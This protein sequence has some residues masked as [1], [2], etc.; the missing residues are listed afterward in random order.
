VELRHR[1]RVTPTL[2]KG[3]A[4][5]V[6][7]ESAVTAFSEHITEDFLGVAWVTCLQGCDAFG[8][9]RRKCGRE[10]L[11]DCGRAQ[12]E[13]NQG[14]SNDEEFETHRQNDRSAAPSRSD[15]PIVDRPPV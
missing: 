1:L 4:E 2:L 7:D 6:V 8:K 3:N 14:G 15:A 9:S 11:R 12:T 10:L 5:V 13:A